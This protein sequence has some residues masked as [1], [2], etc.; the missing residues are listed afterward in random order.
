MTRA[1]WL[2]GIALFFSPAWAC[3]QEPYCAPGSGVIAG[4][5][6]GAIVGVN[7]FAGHSGGEL[8]D[9]PVGARQKT[10]WGKLWPPFPRPVG[11][12][13]PFLHVYHDVHYWPYPYVCQDRETVNLYRDIQAT[14]GWAEAT[15]LYDFHFDPLT[16][17]LNSS[18]RRQL[19]YILTAVPEQ[20]REVHVAVSLNAQDAHSRTRNVEL[21]VAQ[22]AGGS[23]VPVLSRVATPYG[24]PAD[25]VN[26]IFIQALEGMPAPI[27]QSAAGGGSSGGAES[28]GGSTN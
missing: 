19:T 6:G 4:G 9:T 28:G 2:L 13:Q 10:F 17:D 21:A 16:G 8:Y 12:K 1:N 22:L 3:A 11:K 24:R 15:T 7:G 5:N 14:N 27:I 18:G 26:Q 23:S 25:E 20:Y